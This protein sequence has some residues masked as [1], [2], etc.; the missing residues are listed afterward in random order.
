VGGFLSI[1]LKVVIVL[2]FHSLGH[3]VA[4]LEAE[5]STE[6]PLSVG[7][8]MMCIVT[9]SALGWTAILLPLWAIAQ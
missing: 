1:G 5:S 7:A 6:R 9:L 8:A 3:S 4:P 2:A